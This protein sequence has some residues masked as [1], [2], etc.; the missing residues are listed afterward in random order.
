MRQ[1][2]KKPGPS[3]KRGHQA[4][5]QVSAPV[6]QALSDVAVGPDRKLDERRLRRAKQVSRSRLISHFP[7][8]TASRAVPVHVKTI[9]SKPGPDRPPL[10][11]ASQPPAVAPAPVKPQTTAEFLDQAIEQA[12]SHLQPP[13]RR[14]RERLKRNLG[15]GAAIGL[16]VLLLGVIVVQNSANVRLQMASAK[17]GFNVSLPNYRPGGFAL[18][19]LNYSDG[20]A[21]AEFHNKD[22]HYTITQKPTTWDD[23]ALRD[24]FVAPNYKQYQ[25]VLARSLVIYIYGNHNA[26]WVDGG[27][28]YIIQTDGS[29]SDQQIIHLATSF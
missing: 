1:A 15:A 2:V 25:T 3:L 20:V 6:P 21:A 18:G 24:N 27:I 23:L 16:S 12:T 8:L 13:P 10:N 28:W 26:S 22:S 11:A 14:R 29:L 7:P 9:D 19:Q 17:A 4:H 5:G